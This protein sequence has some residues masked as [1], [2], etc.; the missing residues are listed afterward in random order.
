MHN[1]GPMNGK[2]DKSKNFVGSMKRL[3][4][5]LKSFKVL[6]TIALIL[7]IA[8]SVLSIVAPNKLSKLTDEISKGLAVNT[9]NME[10]ITTTVTT[11][12]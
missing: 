2:P 5:E 3:F 1:R 8:G 4:G 9:D 11:N 12:L 10:V 7:A 6:I